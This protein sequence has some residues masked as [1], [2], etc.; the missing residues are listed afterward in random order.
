MSQEKVRGKATAIVLSGS[1]RDVNTLD[2]PSHVVPKEEVVEVPGATFG[3]LLSIGIRRLSATESSATL[4]FGSDGEVNRVQ[5]TGAAAGTPAENCV[6]AALK[7]A[8]VQPFA[9]PSFSL[10]VT[11]RPL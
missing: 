9:A 1:P 10:G 6:E 4:V 11:V 7:K 2:Q 8:R 5:V 3:A